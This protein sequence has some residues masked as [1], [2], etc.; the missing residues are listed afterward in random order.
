MSL[1]TIVQQGALNLGLSAPSMVIGSTDQQTQELQAALNNEGKQLWRT[2]PIL[3]QLMRTGSFTTVNTQVQGALSTLAPDYGYTTHDTVWDRNMAWPIAGP[4]TPQQWQLIE[5][6][7]LQGPWFRYRIKID[8]ATNLNSLYLIPAPP[9][10]ETFYFEYVSKFWVRSA[11]G[12]N[13]Y[14]Q[15]SASDTDEGMIDEHLLQLG[16]EW[17]WLKNKGFE[18]WRD[19]YQDYLMYKGTVFAQD[20][21]QRAFT[22]TGALPPLYP[23]IRQDVQDGNFPAPT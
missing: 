17:R 4:L 21:G 10:G 20:G 14:E 5:A 13:I 16:M 22:I 23:E 2:T 8:P 9:A 3:P 1:L 15:F 19:R 7:M 11:D 12:A 18:N 6:R